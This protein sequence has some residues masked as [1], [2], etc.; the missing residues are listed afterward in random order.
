[1]PR[2]SESTRLPRTAE[3]IENPRNIFMNVMEKENYLIALRKIIPERAMGSLG[4]VSLKKEEKLLK[5]EL[6]FA[7]TYF[8]CRN[9]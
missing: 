7:S 3:R 6:N 5:H 4:V 8:C 9:F 1:M 2:D